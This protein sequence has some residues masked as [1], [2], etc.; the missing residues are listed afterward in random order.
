[1]GKEDSYDK[2]LY[3]VELLDSM[4]AESKSGPIGIGHL[5]ATRE[6]IEIDE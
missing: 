5:V 2:M 6:N 4:K 3:V 1:M